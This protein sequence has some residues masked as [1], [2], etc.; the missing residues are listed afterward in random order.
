MKPHETPNRLKVLLNKEGI[1]DRAPSA[2]E[3]WEVFKLFA[4]E[5]VNCV[6]QYLLFQAG[7]SEMTKDC[8]LDFCRGFCLSGEE[9]VTWWEQ[10]HAEFKVVFPDRLGFP[11][12]DLFSTSCASVSDFFEQVE[13]MPIFQ[14]ALDLD[15]WKFSI[16]HTGV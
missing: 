10:V 14:A 15:G 9:D 16:Y 13:T 2:R 4:L 7:D 12:T 6:D 1:I 11:Q 3:M 5:D 8:Y